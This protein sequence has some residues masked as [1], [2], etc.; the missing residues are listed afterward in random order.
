MSEATICT[1]KFEFDMGHRVL[2]HQGKCRFPHGH[3]YV[4]EVT[5]SAPLDELGFVMDFGLI[6]EQ[7]GSWIDSN[8]DHGFLINAKDEQL[9]AGLAMLDDAKVKVVAFNPTA[10]NIAQWLVEQ[11]QNIMRMYGAS[12]EIDAPRVTHVRL[13]ETP[14]CWAD[15]YASS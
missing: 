12:K 9:R 10:E 14:N 3:R 4:A 8:L 13:Y 6:K 5:L 7:I 2:G 15:A 11:L 1:R